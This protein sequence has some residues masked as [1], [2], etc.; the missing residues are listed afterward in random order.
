MAAGKEDESGNRENEKKESE[1]GRIEDK[2]EANKEPVSDREE[3]KELASGRIE[4]KEEANKEK[5]SKASQT[6]KDGSRSEREQESHN[7]RTG[8]QEIGEEQRVYLLLSAAAIG[9]YLGFRYLSPLVTPF[10]FAF[11]FVTLL[12]PVLEYCQ[13]KLYIRKSI[14]TAGILLLIGTAA[15]LGIWG[16]L[17]F[18]LKKAAGW[19][20][21][22]D[23]FEKKLSFF[24]ADCCQGLELRFGIDGHHME[25]VVLE[26][27]N[28]FIENFQLQV[29]PALMNESMTYARDLAKLVSFFVILVIASVLLAK[30]YTAIMEIL[31]GRKE[32]VPVF[33]I[34]RKVLGHIGVFLKAQLLIL[35]CVSIICALALFLGGIEGGI[36]L[37]L[38]AGIMDVLPFIGTGL[39]L[40]PLAFWQLLN[41]FYGRALLCLAVYGVCALLREFLEPKLVGEKTGIFPVF[42]L[43]SVFTGIG[44]FG[45]FGI[46]KG[47][48][49]LLI[50]YEVFLYLKEHG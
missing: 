41:G 3:G 28:I 27:V 1:T 45:M 35:G 18:V 23:L 5:R 39:I 4:D 2:E 15:G 37:G 12:Q 46:I 30:D 17:L 6:G 47:P 20:G 50:L 34:G 10:L 36:G 8:Q 16:L 43:F 11:L 14:L 32:L 26:R 22:L 33:A 21:H 44:L 9:V 42:I 48:L 24:L 25:E 29:I 40:M 49:A 13:Q 31:R 38:L 19:S 7:R